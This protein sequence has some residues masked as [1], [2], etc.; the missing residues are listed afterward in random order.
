MHGGI[1]RPVVIL[2]VGGLALLSFGVW[3]V[4]A[5]GRSAGAALASSGEPSPSSDEAHA[6]EHALAGEGPTNLSDEQRAAVARSRSRFGLPSDQQ[7]VDRLVAD[8]AA[9][10]RS[11]GLGVPLDPNEPDVV[12][13]RLRAQEEVVSL[14]VE[15]G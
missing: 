11:G 15:L 13:S 9:W 2:V 7:T 12:V 6:P 10:A 1:S 4:G 14:T 3:Q 5:E 8:P